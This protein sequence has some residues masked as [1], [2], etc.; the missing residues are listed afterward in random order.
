M[1]F[2]PVAVGPLGVPSVSRAPASAACTNAV[3]ASC[4]VLVSAAGVVAETVPAFSRL[5]DA[6]LLDEPP[7]DSVLVPAIDSGIIE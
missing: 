1:P 2:V 7:I 5:S 3:V 6:Y 4:V